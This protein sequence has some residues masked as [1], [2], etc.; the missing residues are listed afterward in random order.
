METRIWRL[1]PRKG[2]AS[3]RDSSSVRQE[4]WYSS[5]IPAV[6]EEVVLSVQAGQP[7]FLIGAFGGV[8]RLVI[9]LLDGKPREEATWDC[10]K[11]VPFS[12]EMR[13]L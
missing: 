12:L 11:R 5:R 13:M 7:V 6:L 4:K 1:R 3:T 8:A 2:F 10:Q 9:D